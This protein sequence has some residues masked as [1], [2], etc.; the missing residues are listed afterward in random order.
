MANVIFSEVYKTITIDYTKS[1]QFNGSE[2]PFCVSLVKLGIDNGSLLTVPNTNPVVKVTNVRIIAGI[3]SQTT[4]T[5]TGATIPDQAHV[6]L[7]CG[8]SGFGNYKVHLWTLPTPAT[9]ADAA[10][11]LDT[12]TPLDWVKRK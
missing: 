12:V 5:A 11:K 3:H 7:Q 4:N 8:T 1:A 10:T 9:H 2:Q 6:S